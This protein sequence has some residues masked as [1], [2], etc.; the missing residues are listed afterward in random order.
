MS[1]LDMGGFLSAEV[2]A[3]E[4]K[5]VILL[6]D[7]K[8]RRRGIGKGM[9]LA[10][11]NI[12]LH[13]VKNEFV[14][15]DK[16]GKT[17]AHATKLTWRSGKL[18]KMFRVDYKD[19]ELTG[20]Y[21]AVVPPKQKGRARLLEKGGIVKPKPGHRCLAIP[22]E[23]ARVGQGASLWPKDYPKGTLIRIGMTLFKVRALKTRSN[24]VPMFH[25]VPRV[26]IKGR[27]TLARTLKATSQAT[28]KFIADETLKGFTGRVDRGSGGK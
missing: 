19:G 11:S 9:R 21:G 2:R 5:Q 14:R 22:T 13:H 17:K 6:T 12:A 10:L 25:L 24:L 20:Y 4:L 23:F 16:K 15:G 27:P 28:V 26:K 8:S 7:H 1:L 3:D 18:I